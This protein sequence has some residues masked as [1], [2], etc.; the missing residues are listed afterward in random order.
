MSISLEHAT[1][2]P[3]KHSQLRKLS[4][5]ERADLDSQLLKLQPKGLKE[6]QIDQQNQVRQHTIV[7]VKGKVIAAFGENGWRFYPSNSDG[8]GVN[9]TEIEVINSFREKYGSNLK[10]TSYP[11]GEGPTMGE[12]LEKVYGFKPQPIHVTA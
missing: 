4:S 8:G 5:I 1:E 6:Q 10:V 7:E 12:L 9:K 3:I 2:L 11:D